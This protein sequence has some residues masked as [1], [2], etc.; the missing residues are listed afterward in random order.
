MLDV[1]EMQYFGNLAQTATA[2]FDGD[3]QTNQAEMIAGTN[4]ASGASRFAG[5]VTRAN[6]SA[7]F[8]IAWPSVPGKQYVLEYKSALGGAWLPLATVSGAAVPAA[9]TS[10]PDAAS[11]GQPARFYHVIAQP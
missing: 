7:P 3:G 1:W 5:T 8:V 4:P 10:Y 2:D 9:T 11:I 6:A